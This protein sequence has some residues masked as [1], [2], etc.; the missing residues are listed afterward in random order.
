MK[1]LAIDDNHDNLLTLSALLKAFLPEASLITSQSGA[2]GIRRARLERPDAI[3]LDIQMPGMDGYESTCRLKSSPATQH[4]PIILMTA[5]RTDSACKVRGLECGADAFLAKPIDEAELVAQ[6]K[7]MVR[8]KR[9]EDALREERD[10][11]EELVAKRTSDLLRAN[12][13][14]Q[15]N[16]E[17][18]A[19]SKARYARAVRGTSDG[20][21]DWDLLTGDCYYSPRWKEL[22]GFAADALPNHGDTFFSRLHPDDLPRVE[23]ALQ[24][25]FAGREP[26]N[27]EFRL[28]TRDDSFLRFRSR[29]QAEWDQ[30]GIPVRMSGA[31]TDITEREQMEEQLRQSQKM[32]AVGQLAGGVAHDFNN[33]LTVIS[34]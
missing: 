22:L 29:G 30:R 15:Q 11:L 21:W 28:R 2:D 34:G 31:I 10:G 5:H 3:L 14:L 6:I 26:F 19:E 18:L 7:A 23:A 20:L 32:E 24:D 9:S 4:I 13:E 1:L 27:V 8:I 16:V 12:Q 33:I 25:H 17:R